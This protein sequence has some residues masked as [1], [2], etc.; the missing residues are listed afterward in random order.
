M[1]LLVEAMDAAR[2]EQVFAAAAEA[3]AGPELTA[4]QQLRIEIRDMARRQAPAALSPRPSA[5]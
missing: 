4:D 2:R 1:F 5:V 3:A